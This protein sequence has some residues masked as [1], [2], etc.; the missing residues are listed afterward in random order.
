MPKS[1]NK[2]KPQ[3]AKVEDPKAVIK[4]EP[5][6]S[7]D[8]DVLPLPIPS[9]IHHSGAKE[10]VS[11]NIIYKDHMRLR[12]ITRELEVKSTIEHSQRVTE[13]VQNDRKDDRGVACDMP[14]M[15]EGLTRAE[16]ERIVVH[17]GVTALENLIA[18]GLPLPDRK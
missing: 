14:T 5:R 17:L 9:H 16:I 18:K 3:V 4:D 1:V 15:S 8:E 11:W 7:P 2:A 13:W 6:P 10:K 12:S